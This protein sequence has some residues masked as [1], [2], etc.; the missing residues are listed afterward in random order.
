L[1]S[2]TKSSCPYHRHTFAESDIRIAWKP[3]GET[4]LSRL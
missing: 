3:I 2:E 4:S 1:P